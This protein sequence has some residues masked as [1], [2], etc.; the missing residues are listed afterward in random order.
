MSKEEQNERAARTRLKKQQGGDLSI[1]SEEMF[2]PI[3]DTDLHDANE[4]KLTGNMSPLYRRA[5]GV[6][7]AL[8]A[9]CLFGT[10]FNPAQGVSDAS[11][12]NY[13][14]HINNNTDIPTSQLSYDCNHITTSCMLLGKYPKARAHD[15]HGNMTLKGFCDNLEATNGKVYCIWDETKDICGG[16]PTQHMAFSQ[17]CGIL[18]TSFT[19]YCIYNF[20]KQGIKGVNPWVNIPLIG[21]GFVSGIIWACAQ[22]GWFFAN[23]A[24]SPLISFPITTTAPGLI[25]TMWG[26]VFFNEVSLKTRNVIVLIFAIAIA[27]VADALITM[28]K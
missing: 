20:Y 17:F 8:V 22:I 1:Q 19:Y 3:E 6:G 13:C 11:V 4:G 14:G 25:G 16:I 10:C 2:T 28:S 21:P 12:T 18:L 7:G 23:N 9:G 27:A 5:L 26:I 15:A 24:L